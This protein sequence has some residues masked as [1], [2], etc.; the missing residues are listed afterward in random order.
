MSRLNRQNS[1]FG[2]HLSSPPSSTCHM[3]PLTNTSGNSITWLTCVVEFW[4][5]SSDDWCTGPAFQTHF[6]S[7]RDDRKTMDS[8]MRSAAFFFLHFWLITKG[9]RC[10]LRVAASVS[11]LCLRKLG[12]N[13]NKT[14]TAKVFFHFPAL[15]YFKSRVCPEPQLIN[16]LNLLQTLTVLFG[17]FCFWSSSTVPS[18]VLSG[19]IADLA[20]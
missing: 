6:I 16:P 7:W 8:Q 3:E 18:A 5:I 2:F 15:F 12:K 9:W 1:G 13:D 20:C 11:C 14:D 17:L 19:L 4:C 10:F